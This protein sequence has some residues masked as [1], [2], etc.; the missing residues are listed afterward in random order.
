MKTL[1]EVCIELGVSRRAVQGY[2]A[3]GLVKAT[4]KNKYGHLLYNLH[5]QEKIERI[6]FFQDLGFSVR[7]IAALIDAPK[8]ILKPKLEEQIKQLQADIDRKEHTIQK[9]REL[10][11]T[12]DE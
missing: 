7:E 2:E 3:A 12:L 6:K 10:I 9:A 5:A 1:K 11:K 8:K 4:R